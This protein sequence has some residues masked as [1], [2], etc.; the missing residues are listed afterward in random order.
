MILLA[1]WGSFRIGELLPKH[2][3]EFNTD[4]VFLAS[5]LTFSESSVSCWIRRPKVPKS[6]F[7]DTVEV[8]EVPNRPDL[9][10][11]LALKCYLNYRKIQFGDAKALPLF[12]HEDGSILSKTEFNKD[13]SEL[14]AIYPE[15][16]TNHDKWSGHSFR[17]GISTL[18]STLGYADEDIKSWG[19]WASDAFMVYVKNQAHRRNV[20][21]RMI[22]TFDSML[23][24]I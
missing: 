16:K 5:D 12:L 11:I 9:D 21:M 23:K 19:R 6:P 8:W 1:W 17:S 3:N 14:L 2:K 22:S 4:N 20:R 13:L 10:P 24:G 18:I 7:G 15:L